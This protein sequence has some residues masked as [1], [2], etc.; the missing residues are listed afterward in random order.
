MGKGSV[1]VGANVLVR[2][3]SETSRSIFVNQMNVYMLTRKEDR[4]H[5]RQMPEHSQA[6][7][8]QMPEQMSEHPRTMPENVGLLV[9]AVVDLEWHEG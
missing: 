9:K 5:P 1:H 2:R 3:I 7:P 4:E 8:R 6:I